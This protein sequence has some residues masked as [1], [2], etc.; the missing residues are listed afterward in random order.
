MQVARVIGSA[1]ATAK[2]ST[3]ENKKLL[4]VQPLM[5]DGVKP[6]G[7]PILAV[8]RL[9]AGAGEHVMLTSDGS[10]IKQ[11]FDVD[12]SP[13]RWAVIGI[14]DPEQLSKSS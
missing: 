6:D 2:H 3:L 10:A 13:I 12:N 9:G 4:V 5:A 14:V 7:P 8:D 1:I 11:M